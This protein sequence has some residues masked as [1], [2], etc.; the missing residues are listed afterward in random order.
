MSQTKK[1]K[2][3]L[4]AIFTLLAFFAFGCKK[5]DVAVKNI[6]V[7]LENQAQVVLLVDEFFN[8]GDCVEVSPNYAS[9]KTYS[10]YSMNENVV[11]VVGKQ[12]KAVAVGETMVRVVSNSNETVEDV[13]SVVVQGSQTQLTPPENL[14]LK[15]NEISQTFTFN[16]YDNADSYTI[17]INDREFNIGNVT[18]FALND[19]VGEK[20]NNV[21]TVKV[22]ANAP[23]YGKAFKDSEYS[24]AIRVYQT[25][26]VTSLQIDN[27]KL[28]Y[29]TNPDLVYDVYFDNYKFIENTTSGEIDLLKLDKDFAG[30]SKKVSVDAK[31][32]D[33]KKIPG[34]SYSSSKSD[35]I[36]LNIIDEPD[37]EMI[38][39]VLSWDAVAFA[40]GYNVFVNDVNIAETE[41]NYFDLNNWNGFKNLVAGNENVVKVVSKIS[42]NSKNVAKTLKQGKTAKFTRLQSPDISIFGNGVKWDSVDNASAYFVNL[43]KN[44][45]SEFSGVVAS[46]SFDLSNYAAGDYVV[47]VYAIGNGN[48]VTNNY[49]S[50][51]VATKSVKKHDEVNAEIAG[52]SLKIE[53][54][55][56]EIYKVE[57]VIDDANIYSKEL[58]A[59]GD[60]V[61]VDLSIYNFKAGEHE[62]KIV[63]QGDSNKGTIDGDTKIVKFTQLESASVVISNSVATVARSKTN[64]NAEIYIEIS[65]AALL[66]SIKTKAD[67]Y[68]IN[69]TDK[70]RSYLTAGDYSVVAYVEG[71]GIKTFSYRDVN[72]ANKTQ[73]ISCGQANF[74]VLEV[75]SLTVQDHS[76]A[77]M[78][79]NKVN[80]ATKYTILDYAETNVADIDETDSWKYAFQLGSGEVKQFKVRAIGDGS[81]KLSSL[82]SEAI[83]IARL[84]TPEFTFDATNNSF[85]MNALEADKDR[86]SLVRFWHGVNEKEYT[87]GETYSA[88]KAGENEF[89]IVLVS[90]GEIDDVQYID[91]L[92]SIIKVK[93]LRNALTASVGDNNSLYVDN[94]EDGELL[95]NIDGVEYSID[96]LKT[97]G[98]QCVKHKTGF[99]ISLLNNE[100]KAII[101][102]MADG[103]K[104]K[105]KFLR[106]DSIMEGKTK[107]Y[108]TDSD[109]TNEAELRLKT[110]ATATLIITNN[111]N[112][113]VVE[114][115]NSEQLY[116]DLT[117]NIKGTD[118]EFKDDGF[119]LVNGETIIP[120]TYVG[121]KYYL[122]LYEDGNIKN[123]VEDV[124]QGENIIL[125]VKFRKT[126]EGS[127]IDSAI[128]STKTIQYLIAPNFARESQSLSFVSTY[129]AYELDKYVLIVNGTNEIAM[130]ELSAKFTSAEQGNLIKYTI[131]ASDLWEVLKTEIN[132]FDSLD[133]NSLKIEILN[134]SSTNDIPLLGAIG[135][136]IYIQQ[137]GTFEV[138]T[139]KVSGLTSVEVETEITEYAKIYSLN[140]QDVKE[141]N[142]NDGA[143]ISVSL[144]NLSF[145]GNLNI[146]GY[147]KA[148]SSYINLDKTIYVFDSEMSNSIT[149][150]RLSAPTLSVED[151]KICYTPVSGANGYEVYLE[152]AGDYVKVDENRLNIESN[153]F[154][155]N[156]LDETAYFKVKVKAVTSND[157]V[158]N[159]NLSDEIVVQKLSKATA[160]LENGRVKIYLPNGCGDLVASN[161]VLVKL[162]LN[163]AGKVYD[164]DVYPE[165]L[166]SVEGVVWNGLDAFN[167]NSS[168]IFNYSDEYLI[169][170]QISLQLKLYGELNGVNYI[171]SDLSETEVYGLFAPTDVK[172]EKIDDFADR[173]SWKNNDKNKVARTVDGEIIYDTVDADQYVFAF[174]YEGI[175]YYSTD[176]GLKYLNGS[177]YSSYG[178]ISGT[179]TSVAFPYGYDKDNDGDFADVDD[180]IF[181]NGVYKV[182]V[183]AAKDNYAT[184]PYS[185]EYTFN[186][187]EAPTLSIDDGKLKWAEVTGATSYV[188][189][190][191]S[192]SSVVKIKEVVGLVYDFEDFDKSKNLFSVT[193]Q[194]I[195]N[196]L[197]TLNSK[198]SASLS[199]YRLPTASKIEIDDGKLKVTA[200]PFIY[201]IDI[202]VYIDSAFV[203]TYRVEN[204]KQEENFNSAGL[205]GL[206]SAADVIY[207]IDLAS[208]DS[209]LAG[210]AYDVKIR[211][212]GNTGTKNVAIIGEV[213][214]VNSQ[215]V[216]NSKKAVVLDVNVNNVKSGIWEFK[217]NASLGASG[218]VKLNYNFNNMT[219][220]LHSFWQNTIV[221]KIDV[222][223]YGQGEVKNDVIYAVDYDRF[224]LAVDSGTLTNNT[225]A[226]TYYEMLSNKNGL[227]ARIV[228]KLSEGNLYFNV[229]YDTTDNGKT[230][231]ANIINLQDYDELYYYPIIDKGDFT[232]TS[233]NELQTISLAAGGSFVFN[234]S[235][236]GGDDKSGFVNSYLNAPNYEQTFVRLGRSFASTFK[237]QVVFA[238]LGVE[239]VVCPVYK[240]GVEKINGTEGK[241]YVYLFD[242]TKYTESEVRTHF[243]LTDDVIC[244]PIIYLKES[245]Q[246]AFEM[247]KYF[248]SAAYD[249][250]VR[251]L[252][253]IESDNY[254]LNAKIPTDEDVIIVKI[255]TSPN[256]SISNGNIVFEKSNINNDGVY[257][258]ADNYEIV[259]KSG[260]DEYVGEFNL[261]SEGV[262]VEEVLVGGEIKSYITYMLPAEINEFYITSGHTYQF[263]IRALTTEQGLI[264]SPFIDKDSDKND[265]YI[266]FTRKLAVSDVR[267]E[268]GELKWIGD[269]SDSSKYLVKIVDNNNNKTILLGG[270]YNVLNT[271]K[272]GS[273]YSYSFMDQEY[274][275]LGSK[276]VTKILPGINYTISVSQ[277]GGENII[278]S[279]FDECSGVNRIENILCDEDFVSEDIVAKNGLLTW[280]KIKGAAGYYLE[281]SGE[282]GI[283]IYNIAYEDDE[284]IEDNIISLDLNKVKDLS[285]N[286]LTSG[287]YKAKIRVLAENKI[288]SLMVE[289]LN[290]F[291]K[292]SVV[293]RNSFDFG[294]YITWNAVE[295]ANGYKV[296]FTYKNSDNEDIVESST[297]LTNSIKSPSGVKGKLAI[298]IIAYA[299][300]D[301]TLLNSDSI[302]V[303][304]S[305]TTPNSIKNLRFNE[306]L[307]RFEWEVDDDFINTDKLIVTY[308]L[309][310][311]IDNKGST[312]SENI[313]PIEIS[314]NDAEYYSDGIYYVYVNQMGMYSNFTVIVRRGGAV[315]SDPQQASKDLRWFKF[316]SG[317]E[318]DPY[319]LDSEYSIRNIKYYPTANYKLIDNITLSDSYNSAILT[320]EFSGVIN[321][322]NKTIYFENVDLSNVKEFALFASLNG[323][324]INNLD[325]QANIVNTIS[326]I[327]ADVKIAILAV[328]AK[329][330]IFS[331]V[332]IL[333]ST[334]T[335]KESVINETQEING[336]LYLSGFFAQ[337]ESSTLS[338]CRIQGN[339]DTAIGLA[340]T[341]NI[342][343][344]GY[345][346]FGSVAAYANKTNV[347]NNCN[348]NV[349]FKQSK[350]LIRYLGGVFGFYDGDKDDRTTGVSSSTIR[351]TI[352]NIQTVYIG[353]VVG[354]ANCIYINNNTIDGQISYSD[355]ETDIT[356]GGVTGVAVSS[357]M[358]NNDINSTIEVTLKNANGS[359][360]FGLIVGLLD[361][362]G[363][364]GLSSEV[365]GNYEDYVNNIQTTLKTNEQLEL[366]LIGY[367]DTSNTLIK[368]ETSYSE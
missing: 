310:K 225:S 279:A 364:S 248:D 155:F 295:N 355:V 37:V 13:I 4:L 10:I 269:V 181:A 100:Y 318:T 232:Y 347:T 86:F 28:T 114:N 308:E 332:R 273:N 250:D 79:I 133:V 328:N 77:E 302:L 263:K 352:N 249:I 1:L 275:I 264:N 126:A 306:G 108:Y 144:D 158:L 170:K 89:K 226:Q 96:D 253:G 121:N 183:A 14:N 325:L 368:I 160:K 321:G 19:Y 88:L 222:K 330:S 210:K 169:G 164:C 35:S 287:T 296:K 313:D 176:N 277:I 145:S 44:N 56:D 255:F 3:L 140:V 198:E 128:S 61:N 188:V 146:N 15:Y 326:S 304:T 23:A 297:V 90:D 327:D 179:T 70:A 138:K 266:E 281:L 180:V 120:Y 204:A 199:I 243:N 107:V 230:Y 125:K 131:K 99:E 260:E 51:V 251:A 150:T 118:I 182:M 5:G 341:T 357:L 345:I 72:A 258:Y 201:A 221:Y 103:F 314:Y 307:S 300:D 25:E 227:Y 238:D 233:L 173:I 203:K 291:T 343:L 234:I 52:Y 112:K 65:G 166:T 39:N 193:V 280:T 257:V 63:R 101:S 290:E 335:I 338:S 311:Y 362:D 194:A 73:A 38:G 293:N 135:V 27:G 110:L 129:P 153:S 82:S 245:K 30:L 134:S 139:K 336:N 241:K 363:G 217:N 163:F 187:M 162:A 360:R 20:Y 214:L 212:C 137:A 172:V 218:D 367:Y 229:Y 109:W 8:L 288:N 272:S 22:K 322:E 31:I 18:V 265:D 62:I 48:N 305:E 123:L 192:G 268:N 29:L 68:E 119:K 175:P 247:G 190:I 344:S 309:Y 242:D 33:A 7:K 303:E 45:S 278:S 237:G 208:I 24:S 60:S 167:V 207:P 261:S 141:F 329:D 152:S 256:P 298:E 127:D 331:N 59:T 267:I 259:V 206:L 197:D 315:D 111:D 211:L 57:F 235:T 228:Y 80:Y 195:T 252:A 85:E 124:A 209:N 177:S 294:D 185:S 342:D 174:I 104:V 132:G 196:K 83:T 16:P 340:L 301:I 262:M 220:G 205:S 323:A 339:T 319:A 165:Y 34:V 154:M 184:S 282:S 289:S 149:V 9:D 2:S 178:R 224:K 216:A 41:D 76:K 93:K 316:G 270:E 284:N 286:I 98:L 11:R 78:S 151:N 337:D 189:R 219:T 191:S 142:N 168:L 186:I 215:T 81:S 200:S 117:L 351:F 106:K 353:G 91:S 87:F 69:T 47:E 213:G 147:V 366:G 17:N 143:T 12:I 346:Y 349:E 274:S 97:K 348:I 358:Y 36:L 32:N 67:S 299:G 26:K 113:I 64:E 122:D 84:S 239:G 324:K 43:K 46:T 116:M 333:N 159:S 246:I 354:Y 244:A 105:A 50:S 21:L 312:E 53:A 75:P 285:K 236:L 71:D 359:K 148:E 317:T 356:L 240:I 42:E 58:T 231:K 136:E 157:A 271:S 161:D 74:T 54:V 283:Y 55:A 292:L 171:F 223:T 130:S 95:L 94:S 66:E 254:L 320:T 115:P 49:I 156:D 365:K 92:S 361:V 202:D 276:N 40:G 350:Q 334:I 102:E 6:N